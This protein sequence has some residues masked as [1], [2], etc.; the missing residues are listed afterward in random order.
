MALKDSHIEG[1]SI[2][3]SLHTENLGI[4]HLIRNTLANPHIRYLIICG[5]D[6]RKAIGHSPGQ[7]L[8]ALRE[9]GV[10]DEKRHFF[11]FS[12]L[13]LRDYVQVSAYSD[14]NGDLIATRLARKN[15]KGD[16]GQPEEESE[17][18]GVVSGVNDGLDT[19][20]V[21]GVA[22]QIENASL[23]QTPL[24]NGDLVQVTGSSTSEGWIATEIELIED[25][26][27][28]GSKSQSGL[29]FEFESETDSDH[30]FDP[31]SEHEP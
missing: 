4:E 17:L 5:E 19:I 15:K 14:S 24:A 10:T 3:G 28:P 23:P 11:N 31:D 29:P 25:D 20:S 12:S 2:V 21:S 1:L 26:D 27:G 30:E 22:I 6:T 7:S 18:E 13:N 16:A 8:V 9:H